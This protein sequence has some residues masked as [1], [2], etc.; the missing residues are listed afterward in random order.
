MLWLPTKQ[1][2][3]VTIR[4]KRRRQRRRA[5]RLLL[6][7]GLIFGL[8]TASA[9]PEQALSVQIAEATRPYQFDFINW[10]TEAIANEI[11]RQL[12][13]LWH[14]ED[15]TNQQDVVRQF[16]EQ[17]RQINELE[18]KLRQLYATSETSPTEATELNEEL[19]SLRE[20]QTAIIT[21]VE[22]I[23]AQQVET[24]LRQ[25]GFA[26]GGQILPPVTFR[27]IE[28]PTFL[29]IS[30]REQ[31]KRQQSL[32]LQPGLSVVDRTTIEESLNSRGNVSS[33]VTNI[34]GLGSFPTMVISHDYLPYLIDI[35]IHEWTHNYLFTF[36]SNMAWSHQGHPRL[37]TIN[38]TTAS[39]IGREL[40][41]KVILRYYPEWEAHL[42]P[43]DETGQPQPAEP[44][45]FHLAMRRI[46]QRVDQLLAAGKIEEAEAF[47]EAERLKLVEQGYLLRKLNQAYFAFHGSYALSPSSV[48]PTG[49][50]L[51]QLRAMSPSLKAFLNR[52]GWLNSYEQYQAW[53]AEH[54]IAIT[55]KE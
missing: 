3:K 1:W 49:R 4:F 35:I 38:E 18:R 9:P 45:P 27:L 11:G 53:L 42:P 46:R 12:S 54:E 23:L 7:L 40:S 51:R 15:Y 5:A 16:I 52:V 8:T 31:I 55:L 36:P 25:E 39:L 17:E 19:S 44:S 48:D 28:P 21:Q 2:Q 37:Q 34:G 6:F 24:I 33:Y 20:N 30:P 10:E 47:M 26:I 13:H 41:R 29:I 43:L 22:M 50:Q 32:N 14:G